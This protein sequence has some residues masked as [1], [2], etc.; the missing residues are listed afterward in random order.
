MKEFFL[1]YR[2]TA[3]PADAIIT[4][5]TIPLPAEGAREVIKSYKQAKRKDDDIAIVTSG[6]RVVLDERGVVTDISLAYGGY[7]CSPAIS[8]S[9]LIISEWH[10]KLLRQRTLWRHSSARSGLIIPSL[11]APWRLWKR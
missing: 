11:K 10:R 5:L 7:V 3:L 4:K 6:F 1:T 2:K 9:L 8:Q